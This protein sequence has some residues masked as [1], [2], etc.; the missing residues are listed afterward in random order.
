[1]SLSPG[2]PLSALVVL[3]D[4][5]LPNPD[6]LFQTMRRIVA[7][8]PPIEDARREGPTLTF[9]LGDELATMALY[10]QPIAEEYQEGP[11][12]MAWHWPAA[13]EALEGH[14]RHAALSLAGGEGH[15][16]QRHMLLTAMVRAL[17]EN[18]SAKAVI[19]DGSLVIQPEERF[20]EQSKEI[21]A[22]QLPLMLWVNFILYGGE[23]NTLNLLTKGMEHFG[24]LDLEVRDSPLQPEAVLDA[25]FMVAHLMIEHGDNLPDGARVGPTEDQAVIARQV[26]SI[27]NPGDRTV[28]LELPG[29]SAPLNGN[30]NS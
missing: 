19:W 2:A 5:Y 10:P 24:L 6:L 12:M 20:L 28:L 23:E 17:L 15:P 11:V 30:D 9:R 4:E 27:M 7:D 26:D 1:M 3:E 25:A 14:E 8:I 18:T 21:T 13:G 22:E 29:G 16:V